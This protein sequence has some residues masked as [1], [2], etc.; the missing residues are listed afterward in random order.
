MCSLKSR[1]VCHK[2]PFAIACEFAGELFQQ[3]YDAY[4]D[5]LS[6]IRS[7][8]MRL[9]D[10]KRSE[11]VEDR[12]SSRGGGGP[13]MIGGGIGTLVIVV[14]MLF[15]G[16]DPQA[17]MQ[18]L[19]NQ[20]GLQGQV[21]PD[22]AE[23]GEIDPAREKLKEFA[24][25]VLG[26]TED[27]WG[28]FFKQ[29]GKQ[30]REPTLVLFTGEVNSG[31]GSASSGMGPFYCPA[32]EKVYLDLSFFNQLE[33]EFRAPGDFAQAYV[34]A[35]EVGHH[36]QNV[37]GISNKVHRAQSQLSKEEGNQL[38][39]RLEL[40]ADFYAGV[41]AHHANKRRKILEPGDVE[42]A[43][44]AASAIGDDSLQ[45]QATGR[46]RPDL[47]THGTSQQRLRWFKLGLE[48]G[49]LN[50]GDTFSVDADEL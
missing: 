28:S 49:D 15:L 43:L 24:A 9:D 31:C 29:A 41:W 20:G 21:A 8:M 10:S 48:T 38:S 5:I 19:Q 22:Q 36:V 3:A 26:D 33:R 35:H 18:Q 1:P 37:L 6:F 45:K 2:L 32:D 14:I 16:A 17:I 13:V 7:F 4:H 23:P 40:Q 34:I 42:E 25:R 12:G 47:F 39:V 46:V 27:V 30:Y 11:N 50:R 44:R